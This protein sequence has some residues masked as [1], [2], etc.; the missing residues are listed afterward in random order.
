MFFKSK[1]VQRNRIV[2]YVNL[3]KIKLITIQYFYIFNL[4]VLV[5]VSLLVECS[6]DT[7]VLEIEKSENIIKL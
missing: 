5:T 7:L 1:S 6:S 3:P 2:L 4:V